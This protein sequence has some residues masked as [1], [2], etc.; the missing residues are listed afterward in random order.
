MCVLQVVVVQVGW[1]GVGGGDQV[2]VVY[3]QCVEQVGQDY[4]VVN[5]VD[6]E[7]VQVQYVVLCSDVCGYFY[8]WIGVFVECVQFGVYFFYEVVEVLVQ[9]GVSGQVGDEQVYQE[10][11][12]VVYV[13]LQVQVW[14]GVYWIVVEQ[15]FQ[16]FEQ[17]GVFWYGVE[18]CVYV[19]EF[20]QYGELGWIVFLVMGGY[21]FV[22]VCVGCVGCGIGYGKIGGFRCV[23]VVVSVVWWFLLCYVGLLVG[24]GRSVWFWV[25]VLVWVLF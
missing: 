14:Y 21:V 19:V 15:V 4:C 2:Y 13:V 8:Q 18:C 17:V 12:V 10:G 24:D 5:V 11:F 9:C 7:F 1:C 25:C 3:E 23:W 6:Q 16:L 20:G 22:V